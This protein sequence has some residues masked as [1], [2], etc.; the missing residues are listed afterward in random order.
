[1]SGAESP[2]DRRSVGSEDRRATGSAVRRYD[3]SAISPAV[4]VVETVAEAVGVD[5]TEIADLY[6]YIDPNALDQL[7]R[8]GPTDRPASTF[9]LEF[10]FADSLVTV[11]HDGTVQVRPAD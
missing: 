11:N 7:F 8:P 4:A 10:E 2:D 9:H 1:M 5:P 3:W 6:D